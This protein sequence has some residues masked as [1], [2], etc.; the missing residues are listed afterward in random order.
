[1]AETTDVKVTLRRGRERPVLNGHPWIF[2]GAVESIS[3]EE[4][5][6]GS[7]CDVYS[8][9]GEWLAAGYLNPKSQIICRLVSREEGE[10][11]GPELLGQRLE[12]AAALRERIAPPDTDCLRIVNAEGDG[13]P[14]IIVDRYADGLVVELTTA[15]AERM[16]DE[17]AGWLKKKFKPSFIYENSSEPARAHEGLG[18]LRQALH[19]KPGSRV[20]ITEYGHSFLIDP[21][22]GQKT[23]FYL[24]QR[25]NRRLAANWTFK[26]ARALNLFSYSG[27]FTVYLARAG[28]AHVV[29]VD[30]SEKAIALAGENLAE[31]GLSAKD[32]PLVTADVFDYLRECDEEFDLIVIDPPPFARRSS[33]VRKASRAYKDINRLGLSRLAAGGLMFTFSCSGHVG[34]RLFQQIVFSAALE[35]GK[36]MR[37]LAH[38]GT[39]P[40]H[41]VSLYHPEGEYLKGFMLSAP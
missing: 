6:P 29:S 9:D 41:P 40:D 23:G 32:H 17:L 5:E 13:L 36:E 4:P 19:K 8:S 2:S 12:Q 1:M 14:G 24:D 39:G 31:N 22:Q 38:L 3:P 37:V 10:V 35:A 30:S 11:W 25:E 20:K 21:V 28:A 7:R 26:K 33:H 27:A 18:E 16:R 34:Q 15:G